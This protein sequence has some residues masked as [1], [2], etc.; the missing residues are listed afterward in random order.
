VL[1]QCH[2][3]VQQADRRLQSL[4][5]ST[6]PGM[7]VDPVA[8]SAI[9]GQARQAQAAAEQAARELAATA[10]DLIGPV[11]TSQGGVPSTD[12]NASFV[13][14]THAAS[15]GIVPTGVRE[16]FDAQAASIERQMASAIGGLF[17]AASQSGGATMTIGGSALTSS[18]DTGTLGGTMIIGGN[19]FSSSI[20]APSTGGTMIIGGSSFSSSI[21]APS[22]GGTMIIGGGRS[23]G[24][25]NPMAD[26]INTLTETGANMSRRNAVRIWDQVFPG[27]PAP[28]N[29]AGAI[30]MQ[31]LRRGGDRLTPGILQQ[32]E[33]V[34]RSVNY[35]NAVATLPDG[36]ALIRRVY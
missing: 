7:P 25:G 1:E 15:A 18:S 24:S 36:F 30:L 13:S 12:A 23:G 14:H 11:V 4:V 31:L 5:A 8:V 20:N 6:P 17:G 10:A 3:D 33:V 32:I 21:N 22:T 28:D 35:A 26:A 16:G 2:A 27:V 29:D 19:D 9:V 34:Q